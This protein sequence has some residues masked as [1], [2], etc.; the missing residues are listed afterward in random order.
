[1]LQKSCYQLICIIVCHFVIAVHAQAI[2]QPATQV[3]FEKQIRPLLLQKCGECHGPD[4][5][6][7]D[8]RLDARH[9]AFKGGSSGPVI[10]AGDSKASELIRRI[11]TADT[12]QRMPPD[13]T[14]LSQDEIRLLTSWIDNGAK[15]PE[16]EYDRQ[17]ARDPR[18]DHWAFQPLAIA[19]PI[20]IPN[21]KNRKPDEQQ[22]VPSPNPIAPSPV[23]LAQTLDEFV[24][25]RLTDNDLQFSRPTNRRILIRRLSIDLLGM[26]PT[27]EQVEE[28]VEDEDPE[29]VENLINRLLASPRYGERWAQH[30]LDLV[31][32][33]DTHGFEVNTPRENAWR[34]RD[35]V[36]QAFNEDKPYDRFVKEQIAGDAFDVDEATGFLVASAVLLPGQIG[37][38]DMS[39]RL[40]RQDE[41]DEIITGTS[42]TFLGLTVGC[43]RCHDHKFDPISQRDYYT[44]QAFF[45]GVHYGDRP[46]ENS[47]QK[48]RAAKAKMVGEEIRK[49]ES[50]L[51]QFE[52]RV[53][54]GRTLVIDERN[55]QFA[56]LLDQDNSARA[57]P[58]G[59]KRGFRDDVGSRNRLANISGGYTTWNNAIPG[60]DVLAYRP[61]VTGQ[62]RLWISWGVQGGEMHTRDARYIL[63][64]DGDLS[65]KNDQ[66]EIARVDQRQQVGLEATSIELKSLWSGLKHLG[67]VEL[68]EDS[69]I[70]LR[71]GETGSGISAD[72]IILQE[73]DTQSTNHA[74]QDGIESQPRFLLPR[75]RA[76]VNPGQN[77]EQ[78]HPVSAKFV[79]FTTLETTNNNRYE[80]CIDELEIFGTHSSEKNIALA[81]NGS[82]ATSSGNLSEAGKHQLKHINDG[83]FGNDRSWISNKKGG[84]W[85]QIELPVVTSVNRI[86]WQRDRNLKFADRLA[87][88]YQI[89]VSVDGKKWKTVA[90]H[91]DRQP[92]G[93]PHSWANSILQRMPDE[94]IQNE[95]KQKID[96]LERLRTRKGSL[97]KQELVYGGIFRAPHPTFLLRRGDPEQ[98][99]QPTTPATPD[100]FAGISLPESEPDQ[101]RRLKLASWIASKKNPLTARVMVNRIWQ[102]HFGRGIVSTSSDFGL[103]GQPPS[104][105]ELLD[106]LAHQFIQ[107]GWSVKHIHRLILNSR[108]YQQSSVIPKENINRDD[109][110]LWRF[111]SRRMEAEAIRDSMLA[112]SGE[113][114]LKMGGRGFDFFKSRGGLNGFPPIENFKSEGFR[115]MIYSHKVRMEKTP[116]FGAF[117]CPD[118]GQ[119]MPVRGQ[120]TTAIQALNL[121]NSPFV[122]QRADQFAARVE[123][124]RPG[125]LDN[126]IERAFQLALQRLPNSIEKTKA[127]RIGRQYGLETLCRVLLNT[128]EFLF[129]Q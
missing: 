19:T 14:P 76:A 46:I 64:V 2:A 36:I 87:I 18:R 118:A 70:V 107:S 98:K 127:K 1:M 31:R 112:V 123:R 4:D 58:A 49:L 53:A 75:L 89:E 27:P 116:V 3:D 78:F 39:K 34:Y 77:I 56:T 26:P 21:E 57:N 85:V 45:S 61:G 40:A 15:W 28:F 41:L 32:Y 96:N 86:A 79:R 113:L 69:K 88:R 101:R 7:S 119:P 11:T 97:E 23:L 43:A 48:Q 50:E 68:K 60:K 103:N 74:G 51:R 81:S 33:A 105:P 8:L 55:E 93:T 25:R 71:S 110:W 16:T 54:S 67:A 126:Q 83:V 59:S 125:S 65:S 42:A 121:F 30:W 12:D 9:A 24:K 109:K 13:D 108:V 20:K 29:A 99:L 115:R 62:F 63:D 124:E 22:V 35:Y 128:N 38:D 52:P 92:Y 72:V 44:L 66:A 10:V 91:D 100:V 117:D 94:A 114:N 5:Q 37:K 90:S 84:G 111:P 120:S 104:N 47:E 80:P 129:I 95:V 6:T 102:F 106:W 73:I 82:I 17:A 122:I